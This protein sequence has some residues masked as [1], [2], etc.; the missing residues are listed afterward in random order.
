MAGH[1]QQMIVTNYANYLY[2]MEKQNF[3]AVEGSFTLY[4]FFFLLPSFLPGKNKSFE[5]PM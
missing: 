1:K 5:T 4:S 3:S 2:R